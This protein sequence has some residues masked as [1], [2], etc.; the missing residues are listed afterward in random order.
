MILCTTEGEDFGRSGGRVVFTPGGVK[1]RSI[2]I[3][4]T[5]DQQTETDEKLVVSFSSEDIPADRQDMIPSPTVIIIDN[6]IS[7]L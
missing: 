4:I 6:D 2:E 7:E 3:Q 5:D 1:Q